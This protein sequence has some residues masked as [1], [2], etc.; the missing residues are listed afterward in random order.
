MSKHM[1]QRSGPRRTF[2]PDPGHECPGTGKRS[3]PSRHQA[4]THLRD[5]R[6]HHNC[7]GCVYCCLWFCGWHV[8][9]QAPSFAKGGRYENS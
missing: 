7:R 6:R 4:K 3:H 2:C 9:R 8:G 5:L 1:A